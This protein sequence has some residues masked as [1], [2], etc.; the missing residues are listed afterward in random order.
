MQTEIKVSSISAFTIPVF[1]TIL[2]GKTD[3]LELAKGILDNVIQTDDEYSTLQTPANFFVDPLCEIITTLVREIMKSCGY[4]SYKLEITSMWG[5]VQRKGN[6]IFKHTHANSVFS[7][8]FYL[9]EDSNFPPIQ[10]HRPAESSFDIMTDDEN[11][12]NRGKMFLHPK[13][14]MIV[15]FPS[16]LEH[17]VP[18][19]TSGKD[20]LSI[21]FNIMCRGR[22]GQKNSRQ[23]VII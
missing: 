5:N 14:D 8:V 17:D 2:E 6:Y 21:S 3:E 13:R 20:R 18:V 22:F 12:F 1:T 7:G 19:N 15:I 10:F 4:A 16:W 23:E 11:E 9:N